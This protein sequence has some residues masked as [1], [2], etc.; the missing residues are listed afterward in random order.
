[1]GVKARKRWDSCLV[2]FLASLSALGLTLSCIRATEDVSPQQTGAAEA[3]G[4]ACKIDGENNA[5]NR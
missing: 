5:F 4:D 2:W 3:A 1:M